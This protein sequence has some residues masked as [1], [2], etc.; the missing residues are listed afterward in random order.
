MNEHYLNGLLEKYYA[1]ETTDEEEKALT[2]LLMSEDL[3]ESYH[4][5]RAE[6]RA[7]HVLQESLK[8]SSGFVRRLE[9]NLGGQRKKRVFS[10]LYGLRKV[11]AVLVLVAAGFLA[12]NY[13]HSLNRKDHT[14]A[15][16]DGKENDISIERLPLANDRLA[17]VAQFESHDL[18]NPKIVN[19]LIKVLLTDSSEN[20]RLEALRVLARYIDK[21]TV[22]QAF[23]ASIDMQDSEL[24]LY[25]MVDLAV[26]G[27][28]KESIPVFEEIIQKNTVSP[29]LRDEMLNAVKLLNEANR[30]KL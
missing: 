2:A 7:L 30:V 20:V 3:P 10:V 29:V 27:G 26:V 17:Q 6:F 28:I 23:V 13:F 18:A 8:P 25:D 22:K 11:A 15:V 24:V 16:I 9:E 5:H 1:G 19:L 14:A 21:T 12:G 4:A